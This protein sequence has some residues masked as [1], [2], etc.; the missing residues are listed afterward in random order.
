MFD[1]EFH[2]TV[3]KIL[4]WSEAPKTMYNN[5]PESLMAKRTNASCYKN[6]L[7]SLKTMSSKSKQLHEYVAASYPRYFL[8]TTSLPYIGDQL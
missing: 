3:K 2:K 7:T 6:A 8:F 4:D 1:L 5:T